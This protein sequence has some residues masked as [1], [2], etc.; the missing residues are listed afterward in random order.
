MFGFQAVGFEFRFQALQF[1][2]QGVVFS[3]GV[4]AGV[5]GDLGFC[6]KVVDGLVVGRGQG[7]FELLLEV[8][9]LG[10]GVVDGVFCGVELLSVG[11]HGGVVSLGFEEEIVP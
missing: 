11:E 8:F 7:F 1:L 3:L 5:V 4:F 6:E 10:F 2:K 9:E